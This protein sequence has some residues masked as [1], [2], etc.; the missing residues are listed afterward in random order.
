MKT[1]IYFAFMM[2]SLFAVNLAAQ[3]SRIAGDTFGLF[4]NDA[5][6]FMDPN[7]YGT[8]EFE[9]FFSYI[10]YSPDFEQAY[11]LFS[12]PKPNSMGS[13][14]LSAGY[15]GYFGNVYVGG[16]FEG[17]LYERF[18]STLAPDGNAY[19]AYNT[20][21][22]LTG[23]EPIGGIVLMAGY[24]YRD[25]TIG[26]V[27]GSLERLSFGGGWGKNFALNNGFLLKPQ[28]GFMYSED[29]INL[30]RLV[31]DRLYDLFV[32]ISMGASDIDHY[33][34]G[35]AGADLELVRQGDA[36]P[37]LSVESHLSIL[38]CG[39]RRPFIYF[40]DLTSVFTI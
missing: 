3:S 32:G 28:L 31:K 15:A 20:L 27:S 18:W 10:R 8:V 25:Q 13:D 16:F 23:A 12:V 38:T 7:D 30:P 2:L 40:Q 36:L 22:V 14:T 39:C 35:N 1:K 24:R 37:V 29:D 26:G 21:S 6:S 17:N 5:D 4:R 9:K 19:T 34:V 33:I 11:D